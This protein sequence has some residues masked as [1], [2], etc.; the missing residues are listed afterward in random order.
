MAADLIAPI[1]QLRIALREVEPPIWR[2]VQVPA[3]ITLPRLHRVFQIVMG[4]TDS[5][6]HEFTIAGRRYGQ[7]DPDFEDYDLL[8]ERSVRLG[9]VVL[10]PKTRFAYRC[11]RGRAAASTR[12][13]S[14]ST[15]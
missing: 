2:R 7:P 11:S 8:P 1:Y 5:H 4:W 12:R 6:L 15:P 13:P 9:D 14:T 10:R 3:D